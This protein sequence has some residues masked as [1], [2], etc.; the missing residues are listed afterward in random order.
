MAPMT[1]KTT[2]RMVPF[3]PPP[4]APPVGRVK[5]RDGGLLTNISLSASPSLACINPDSCHTAS[6][7]GLPL[8]RALS[9]PC[10]ARSLCPAAKS[11]VAR[12]DAG[13][14]V[15]G[16]V[17]TPADSKRIEYILLWRRVWE[18]ACAERRG[19]N[20]V[21]HG[22]RFSTP[23]PLVKQREKTQANKHTPAAS[24]PATCETPLPRTFIF[25][26]L[27]AIVR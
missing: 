7:A 14:R 6:G 2:S 4:P 18:R 24:K 16:Y 27:S 25:T 1:R 12:S 19:G 8:S 5:E 22:H 10:L 23:L 20:S 11:R 9:L 17:C 21:N 15:W 26:E 3:R 13:D